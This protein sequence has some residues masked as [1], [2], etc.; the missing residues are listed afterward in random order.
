MR[1][2]LYGAALLGLSAC[3]QTPPAPPAGA[4]WVQVD[5]QGQ[6]RLHATG[7]SRGAVLDE[8]QGLAQVEV[9]PQPPRDDKFEVMAEGLTLDEALMR[10][11]P[12]GRYVLRFGERERVL[13][14]LDKGTKRGPQWQAPP[15]AVAK[16][17]RRA[18]FVKTGVLKAAP[19]QIERP[20]RIDGGKAAPAELLRV[21]DNTGAKKAA[22][23]PV[24]RATVRL[25]LEITEGQAP[26]VIAAQAIEGRA[27][28]ERL[29]TGTYVFVL[30][31]ADGRPAQYG[32]FQD[33]LI[34]HSYLPEGRHTE[35]RAKSGVVGI[36]VPRAALDQARLVL[37]DAR[38][39][40]LPASLDDE[41]VR[42]LLKRAKPVLELEGARIARALDQ[43][44]LK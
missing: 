32:S 25:T 6:Y 1:W 37:L 16:D 29:V 26:R 42:G 2:T 33:P 30:V 28:I 24:E 9:R 27:P 14:P 43:E 19:E 3:V 39:A 35:T 12:E 22:P 34:E 31:D 40:A 7:V 36:S 5:A 10:L 20:V 8:L 17:E 15:D 38:D 13:P 41:A 21:A 18:S 11:L 4:R 44:T 23:V